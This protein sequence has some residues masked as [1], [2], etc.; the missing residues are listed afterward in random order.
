MKPSHTVN[1]AIKQL[2]SIS[3]TALIFSSLPAQANNSVEDAYLE[4][5]PVILSASRLAQPLLETPASV[6]VIDRK[7]I[8]QSGARHIPEL[9]RYVPGMQLGHA[10]DNAP[11]VV[12]HGLGDR[13]SRRVQ[14][15]IDGRSVY[16]PAFGGVSWENLPITVDDIE[17]IEVIRGPN[18]ALYGS[19]SFSAVISITTRFAAGTVQTGFS[20]TVENS[21]N[22]MLNA[23]WSNT[24]QNIDYAVSSFYYTDEGDTNS[25]SRSEADD[26]R[27]KSISFSVNAPISDLD[28]LHLDAGT[29][30]ADGKIGNGDA[31]SA[32]RNNQRDYDYLRLKHDHQFESGGN[33]YFQASYTR[34]EHQ[35]DTH[36]LPIDVGTGPLFT[37]TF[38][39]SYRSSRTE[40]ESVYTSEALGSFRYV[41]G[42]SLRRDK[43]MSASNLASTETVDV[44]RGFINTEYKLGSS[45]LFGLGGMYEEHDYSGSSFSPKLS[46]VQ[47]LGE[48]YALRFIASQATRSPIAFENNGHFTTGIDFNPALLAA[49]LPIFT[50][51]IPEHIDALTI[52]GTN[53]LRNEEQTSF[54]V[55]FK[56]I[57]NNIAQSQL[58]VRLFYDELDSLISEYDRIS[59]ANLYSPQEADTLIALA[60]LEQSND[61]D[62]SSLGREFRRFLEVE[63]FKNFID[64]KKYG[65]EVEYQQQLTQKLQLS[66]GAAIIRMQSTNSAAEQQAM[67]NS[68][69]SPTDIN[70][71]LRELPAT[72]PRQSIYSSLNYRPND[73]ASL[74]ISYHYVGNSSWLGDGEPNLGIQRM[75]NVYT[76]V[77][78]PVGRGKLLKIGFGIQNLTND[79]YIDYNPR[80][81]SEISSYFRIGLD[82]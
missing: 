3:T 65:V 26:D 80:N 52:Q 79:N 78:Q 66:S 39:N 63:L 73:M 54:E 34:E 14:V 77:R 33:L 12:Y 21:Q 30:R 82:F 44:L 5:F 49:T 20:S 43:V 57:F 56:A 70:N 72:A 8:E 55:G 27:R 32:I 59:S 48:Q 64:L 2:I 71:R 22:N 60:S 4:D 42:G 31:T 28:N 62:I 36:V 74:N 46:L 67:L 81:E 58:D 19:N 7:L 17:K 18:A 41:A 24:Y 9:F 13:Y 47:L 68:G 45:T 50:A 16:T 51:P 38:D 1:I 10:T 25:V 69:L 15:L 23:H 6:T 75:V 76:E 61:D 29:L 37:A 35:D 11:V 40:I 53:D